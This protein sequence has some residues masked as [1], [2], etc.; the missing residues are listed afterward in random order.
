MMSGA[1]I[2]QVTDYLRQLTETVRTESSDGARLVSDLKN[3]PICRVT[4]DQAVP[5]ISLTWGRYATSAQLRFVHECVLE[6][7]KREGLG[8]ILGDDSALAV[9]P[10]DDQAWLCEDWM[11]R[12]AVA[13]LKAA[14]SKSP[15][16]FFG[17]Q[18]VANVQSGAPPE[19]A[20]R[21]F[22]TLDE[23]RAWLQSVSF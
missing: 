21:S 6:L 3:N 10:V 2:G 15:Q 13:G 19:I 17:K 1:A 9:I 5:C 20:L 22:D 7:L 12:A 14:A 4:L 8:K 18:S 16:A 23:A 11:P